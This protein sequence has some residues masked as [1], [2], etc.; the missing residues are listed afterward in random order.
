MTDFAKFNRRQRG[1]AFARRYFQRAIETGN[2]R[3]AWRGAEMILR[4][5]SWRLFGD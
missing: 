4:L 3:Q 2:M 5:E 1:L